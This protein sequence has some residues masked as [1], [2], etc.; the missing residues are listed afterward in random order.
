MVASYRPS[1]Y[2][3]ET[4][5]FFYVKNLIRALLN[6]P[7][8]VKVSLTAQYKHF[9]AY[10]LIQGVGVVSTKKSIFSIFGSLLLPQ[11]AFQFT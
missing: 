1:S 9:S 3:S 5:T 2:D 10:Q 4:K 7:K 11:A 8:L 6:Y